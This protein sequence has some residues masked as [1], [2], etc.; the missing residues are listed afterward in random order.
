MKGISALIATVLLIAFTVGTAGIISVWLTSFTKEQTGTIGNQASNSVICSY[1]GI[2]L[3]SLTFN[4]TTGLL[5]GS[6]ENT[7]TVALGNVSLQILYTNSSDQK[8][9]LCKVGSQAVNCTTANLTLSPRE[10][11]SF[12]VAI[13]S[14]Y[15]KI[16]T[17]TNCSSVYDEA[18]S[19]EVS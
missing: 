2:N 14:N 15:D 6:V 11:S 19:T 18:A 17:Y 16:R 1:G 9:P 8:N 5:N 12:S 3:R 10:M 13:G 4:G 7:G